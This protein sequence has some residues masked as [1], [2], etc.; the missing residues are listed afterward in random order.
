[1]NICEGRYAQH[2]QF[3]LGMGGWVA[4]KYFSAGFTVIFLNSFSFLLGDSLKPRRREGVHVMTP[5]PDEMAPAGEDGAG[6]RQGVVKWFSFSRGYGFITDT[7]SGEE[8]F[9]HQVSGSGSS[10]S[11]VK[12]VTFFS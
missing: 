1:M 3:W 8:Y 10:D 11:T 12:C 2:A 4:N 6:S 5:D 7:Q 9:V